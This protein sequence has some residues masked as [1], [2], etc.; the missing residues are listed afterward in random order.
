M[1][2]IEELELRLKLSAFRRR[3]WIP[4]VVDDDGAPTDSKFSGRPFLAPGESWPKCGNCGQP[5]QLFVQLNA[6]DLPADSERALDGGILQFFYCTSERPHCEGE[7]EAYFPNAKSTLLRLLAPQGV[8]PSVAEEPSV[9]MFPP[10]RI[11]SWTEVPDYPNW[12]EL[13][14]L[15]IELA[16]EESDTLAEQDFPHIGD[17]LLGWPAWVQGVE[18]P[19]CPECGARMELLFQID[20]EDNVP[21]MFGDT[22]TGHITQCP[23]HRNRLAFGWACC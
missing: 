4:E 10:R 20:S 9:D 23:V 15:G 7:C 8:A 16:D 14:E 3:A 12:E 11:V 22:G 1:S 19:S 21:Y 2:D 6:R 18:Y 17:K 13:D 5:M